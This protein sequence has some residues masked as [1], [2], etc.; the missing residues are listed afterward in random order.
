MPR[1]EIIPDGWDEKKRG[2]GTPTVDLCR[3]CALE[4]VEGEPVPDWLDE[5][6]FEATIG[7]TDVAHPSYEDKLEDEDSSVCEHCGVELVETDNNY[8]DA[9]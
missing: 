8:D 9:W 4:L 6:Y 2:D 5:I 3:S 1:V 7:S